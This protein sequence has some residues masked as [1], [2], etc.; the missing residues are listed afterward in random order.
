MDSPS[1]RRRD[2]LNGR[3]VHGSPL[4]RREFLRITAGAGVLLGLAACTAAPSNQSPSATTA[5]ATTKPA[6][7]KALTLPSY[8][9]PANMPAPDFPGSADGV[10]APGLG[11]L[12]QDQLP[13]GQAGAW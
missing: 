6:A 7:A 12:A 4:S 10:V 2:L 5:P 13:V 1:Y 3:S 8:Q 9:P 11:E